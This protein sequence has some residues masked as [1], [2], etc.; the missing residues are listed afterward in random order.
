MEARALARKERPRKK[1]RPDMPTASM[2]DG[3]RP[4]EENRKK[5]A[6]TQKRDATS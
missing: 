4:R 1:N 2:S 3:L 6:D 5:V